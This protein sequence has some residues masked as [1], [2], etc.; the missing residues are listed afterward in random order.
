MNN[1]TACIVM[2]WSQ[3][4]ADVVKPLI[5]I[6]IV[7][8]VIHFLFW[9]NLIA[10][11]TVR[12]RS[13]QWLYAY[14]ATDLILLLRFFLL[15]AYRWSP[16]CVPHLLRTIIC[17][18]EAILDSYLNLLQS[19]IVLALNICRYLQVTRTYDVYLSSNHTIIIS[20]FLIY[21]LPL[22]YYVI[23]IICYQL[24]LE[25]PPGDACDLIFTSISMQIIFL[26]FSYFIPVILTLVFLLLSLN[27]I[28]NT[29]GIRTQKII[30]ARLKYHRQ[31]VIQS[32]VFYSLWLLLWSPY[33]L[34]FPFYYRHSIIGSVTQIL[35]Y[36][37]LA[38]DPIVIAS[39]DVRFL[40][41]WQSTWNHLMR[42]IRSTSVTPVPAAILPKY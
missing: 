13:M 19:Y 31:L 8:A 6:C 34:L 41:A 17:Y 24:V 38:L 4:A 35:S 16:I 18:C 42:Y 33:L 5:S 12:Q 32:V 15:Y 37:S 23:A 9:I 29:D 7:A 27:Y 39:L 1:E 22:L 11:P 21:I 30:D 28:R 25:R 26:L 20:H 2:I 36:V 40:R 3:Q 14:L 10:Y